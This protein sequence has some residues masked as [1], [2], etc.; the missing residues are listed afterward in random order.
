M[1]KATTRSK[2]PERPAAQ[3]EVQ[4]GHVELLPPHLNEEE[5]I[6]CEDG[7]L[8]VQDPGPDTVKNRELLKGPRKNNEEFK[9]P[10]ERE[11]NHEDKVSD[12]NLLKMCCSDLGTTQQG[13]SM[14]TE[15]QLDDLKKFFKKLELSAVAC[16]SLVLLIVLPVPNFAGEEIVYL[17]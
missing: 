16:L 5:G 15:G 6:F 13:L 17:A 10:E 4:D 11:A 14:M 7:D 8:H 3:P 2:A 1:P 9:G 12:G